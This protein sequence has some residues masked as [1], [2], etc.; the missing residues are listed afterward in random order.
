MQGTGLPLG[1]VQCFQYAQWTAAEIPII[2]ILPTFING[3]NEVER[4]VIGSSNRLEWGVNK[5]KFHK[6]IKVSFIRKKK[7]FL[8]LDGNDTGKTINPG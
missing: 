7:F 3:F 2:S 5:K 4:M 6:I 8:S 1:N